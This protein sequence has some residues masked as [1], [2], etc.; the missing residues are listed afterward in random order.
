MTRDDKTAFGR[1][2][3]FHRFPTSDE[4][5]RARPIPFARPQTFRQA[6]S[7]STAPPPMFAF[8]S[9]LDAAVCCLSPTWSI[10]LNRARAASRRPSLRRGLCHPDEIRDK[11]IVSIGYRHWDDERCLLTPT[12]VP[13]RTETMT[14]RPAGA[15]PR[16]VCAMG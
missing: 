3:R 4:I 12:S 13:G 15:A 14:K 8:G 16:P 6:P 2:T 5:G 1:R 10:G 7:N 11:R 9:D